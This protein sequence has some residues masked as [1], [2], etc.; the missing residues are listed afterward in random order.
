M[1]VS[2]RNGLCSASAVHY[3]ISD[4]HPIHVKQNMA[5]SL[6][7]LISVTLVCVQELHQLY[8]VAASRDNTS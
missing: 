7:Q 4:N 3:C 6:T 5:E 2:A 1:H 8:S